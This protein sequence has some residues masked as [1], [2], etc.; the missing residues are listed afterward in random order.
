MADNEV[1][2]RFRVTEPLLLSPFTFGT[3]DGKQGFYGI[4]TLNFQ[5]NMMSNANRAWRSV[6]FPGRTG[7]F[8]K[9]AQIESFEN[10][11]LTFQFITPHASE[12]LTLQECRALL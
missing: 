9:T 5:M 3:T 12:L 8:V 1:Y 6:R 7:D 10:S 4:Q 2:V 11:Q